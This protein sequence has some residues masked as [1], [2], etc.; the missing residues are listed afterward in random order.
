LW[1]PPA[2]LVGNIIKRCSSVFTDIVV[3]LANLSF[4]QG[5]FPTNYK[6]AVTPL[7]KKPSLDASL[8]ANYRPISNLNNISKIL[9]KL[10]MARLQP[11][12]VSSPNFNQL[13][14]AY[15]ALHSTET[16]LLHTLDAIYRSSDQGRPTVLISIDLSSAFDMV[17]HSVL[18]NRLYNSFGISGTAFSWICSYI[19]GRSQCVRA[20]QSSSAYKDCFSGVSQGSVLG[21]LLFS[22]YVSPIGCFFWLKM[23][24]ASLHVLSQPF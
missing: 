17:D 12:I 10:F 4:E 9:E 23:S 19:R 18:L 16:A 14:S 1:G 3:N 21:P 7:L 11:H 8:P 15:R 5:K 20:G 13:Q 2:Q 22:V 6:A 24:S